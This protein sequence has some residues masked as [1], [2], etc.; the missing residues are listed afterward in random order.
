MKKTVYCTILAIVGLL[1]ACSG[2]RASDTA[3]RRLAVS[4]EPLRALLEPLARGRFEVAGVM[5]RGGDPENFEPSISRRMAVDAS[6][7]FFITGGLPFERTLADAAPPAVNVVDVSQ[8]I[9][10]VYGTHDHCGHAHAE[11]ENHAHG[12]PDPHIWTSARNA[13]RIAATMAATLARLDPDAAPL[14]A[15]RLDSLD[16]VLATLDSTAA[17]T[18]AA[19]GARAFMVWHPSLSYL[20]RDY[21]LRQVA[22]GAEG[23]DFSAAGMRDAIRDARDARAGVFF[24]QRGLDPAQAAGVCREA[25]ARTVAIDPLAYDWQQQIKTIADELAR[26]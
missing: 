3:T 5:D 15:A 13:R 22:L 20:A 11:G 26:H 4:I 9:D 17:A 8:G 24:V 14:Y 7:A 12:M 25:G 1:A 21:G 10:P 16:A 23:K 2:G 18:I 19:S 6:E